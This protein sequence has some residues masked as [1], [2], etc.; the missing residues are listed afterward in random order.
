[1]KQRQERNNRELKE[2]KQRLEVEQAEAAAEAAE[3]EASLQR[4]EDCVSILTGLARLEASL[5]ADRRTAKAALR[6]YEIKLAGV[7]CCVPNFEL[8]DLRA[9]S[10]RLGAQYDRT[11]LSVSRLR[12]AAKENNCLPASLSA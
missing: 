4:V 5:E 10:G 2:V 7:V 9:A 12:I 6:H 3:A 8:E 1:M 11:A